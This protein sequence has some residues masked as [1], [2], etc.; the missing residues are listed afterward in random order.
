MHVGLESLVFPA[1]AFFRRKLKK[2]S[3]PFFRKKKGTQ[4]WPLFGLF[5]PRNLIVF[6]L[7]IVMSVGPVLSCVSCCR[8]LRGGCLH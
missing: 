6:S 8:R 1:E 4:L 7:S 3:A 2:L 5:E